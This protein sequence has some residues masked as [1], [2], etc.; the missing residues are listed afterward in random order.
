MDGVVMSSEE[1]RTWIMGLVAVGGYLTYL[2]I[3]LSAG[4][5]LPEVDYVPAML[6]TIGGA[7]LVSIVLNIV[8]GIFTPR[9]GAT[10]DQRD[11]EIYQTSERIGQSFLV[12]GGVVAMLLAM[13]ELGYFW[14]A[15]VLYLCFVLSAILSC[16]ARII[17]YRRGFQ[18]W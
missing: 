14:I 11:R 12:I 1:K 3:L 18:S 7:I 16:T 10:K 9:A 17:A 15:N 5:P 13:F 8:V 4:A 2:V 6:W